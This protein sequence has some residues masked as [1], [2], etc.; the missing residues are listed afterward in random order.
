VVGV[1]CLLLAASALVQGAPIGFPQHPPDIVSE[2][3]SVSY[4]PTTDSFTATGMARRYNQPPLHDIDLAA[5]TFSLSAI[6]DGNGV[7]SSGLVTILGGIPDLSIPGGS[8]L[9]TGSLYQFG[10]EPDGYRTPPD[11]LGPGSFYFVCTV[12]GGELAADYGGVGKAF[13]VLLNTSDVF[14]GKFDSPFNAVGAAAD[15]YYIPEPASFSILA[16]GLLAAYAR[17]RRRNASR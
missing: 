8:T 9:L 3:I 7:A 16:A 11:P 10:F 2:N 5:D 13:E 1:V 14:S 4:D 17:R 15:T 6:I 12:T